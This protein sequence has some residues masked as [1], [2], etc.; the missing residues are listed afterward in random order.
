MQISQ[1]VSV[2]ISL[3]Q[4]VSIVKPH[5]FL[6]YTH[7]YTRSVRAHIR[8]KHHHFLILL[9]PQYPPVAHHRRPQTPQ[10]HPDI[11]PH[12]TGRQDVDAS[13]PHPA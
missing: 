6:S 9:R 12:T 3:Y 10:R 1:F 5:T 4:W 11:A 8:S 13:G 7:P 2:I